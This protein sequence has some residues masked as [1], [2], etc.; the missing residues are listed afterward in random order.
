MF[1][2]TIRIQCAVIYTLPPPSIYNVTQSFESTFEVY[3]ETTLGETRSVDDKS[4]I[5]DT[6]VDF[7]R[8]TTERTTVPEVGRR[9]R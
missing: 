8:V 4:N 5:G 7:D 2:N 9:R 6:G 3:E 1:L